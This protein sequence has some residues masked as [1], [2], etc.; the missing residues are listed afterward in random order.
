MD[1]LE[2]AMPA[3]LRRRHAAQWNPA[4]VHFL[5]A[6]ARQPRALP[7]SAGCSRCGSALQRALRFWDSGTAPMRH[8]GAVAHP[9]VGDHRVT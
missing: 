8:T 9:D 3:W 4:W 6:R 2:T 5:Q 7:D 1:E